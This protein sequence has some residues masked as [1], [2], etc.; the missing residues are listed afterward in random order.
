MPYKYITS[1]DN[2][3]HLSEEMKKKLRKVEKVY[4]FRATDY[5]LSLINWDDPDDP[6]RKIVIPHEHELEP[7]GYI[8]PSNEKNYTVMPGV[9]HKYPQTVLILASNVCAGICR[10]CF[11]KRIFMKEY[12]EFVRNFPQLID[13]LK[14]HKEV[15][16]VLLS[17]GDPMVLS[18]ERLEY[19]IKRIREVDHI[20]IIRIGTK[21][22]VYNPYRIIEDPSLLEM[23]SR[24]STDEKKIY[25]ITD[26]NHP[27]ELTPQAIKALNLLQKAGAILANQTPLIRGLNDSVEVLTALF[28][29]LSF[30]GVPPYYVF[31]CRP[32]VGNK[33]FAVPIERGLEILE[34]T[35]KNCS[36]LAKRARFIMS[37]TTGKIEIVGMTDTHIYMKYMSAVDESM[38]GK[39]MVFRRN[40]N[41]YWLE[42]YLRAERGEEEVSEEGAQPQEIA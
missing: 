23:I 28:R 35:K 31:Q 32:T 12:M 4:R 36:G 37:H 40:P 29:K 41:A 9:E 14:K 30:I 18:T 26:I 34:E 39:L 17:G 16:N 1:L 5:Y 19:M 22:P 2:V 21:V 11:R 13:Y 24:Y 27:K 33:Y 8:D 7:W 3:P 42:D 10:F 25:V 15:T 6:I 20:Q 38:Y